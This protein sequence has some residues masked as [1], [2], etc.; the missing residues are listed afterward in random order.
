LRAY[1]QKQSDYL[2]LL[3]S[4]KLND[5]ISDSALDRHC[6]LWVFRMNFENLISVY[7]EDMSQFLAGL[8]SYPAAKMTRLNKRRKVKMERQDE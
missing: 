7:L 1:E 8:S 6:L 4:R 2:G 5:P 3:A